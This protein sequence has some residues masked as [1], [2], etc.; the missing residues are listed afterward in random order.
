VLGMRV[1]EG[2]LANILMWS[3]SVFYPHYLHVVPLFGLSPH[4]DQSLGGVA[5]LLEGGT[6]SILVLGWFFYR[7]LADGET[8]DELVR[9]GVPPARAD[10]AVRY[11]RGAELK[12]R[13]GRLQHRPPAAR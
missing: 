2:L 7:F 12:D 9:M 3:Q 10:R 5:M 4:E 8:R 6:T 1:I 13:I 11:G